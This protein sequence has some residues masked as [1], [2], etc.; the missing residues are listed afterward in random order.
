MTNRTEEFGATYNPVSKNGLPVLGSWVNAFPESSFNGTGLRLDNE[1]QFIPSE[2]AAIINCVFAEPTGEVAFDAKMSGYF[3][4]FIFTEDLFCANITMLLNDKP[5]WPSFK[6][7]QPFEEDL[8]LE[9]V[10]YPEWFAYT[11]M[12]RTLY[13]CYQFIEA[14]V[15]EPDAFEFA[16]EE[17][18]IYSEL[19]SESLEFWNTLKRLKHDCKLDRNKHDISINMLGMDIEAQKKTFKDQENPLLEVYINNIDLGFEVK[20][21]QEGQSSLV[22]QINAHLHNK[23]RLLPL[24][25][26]IL[27]RLS[28]INALLYGVF[29]LREMGYVMPDDMKET[30]KNI[31]Y[32][33]QQRLEENGDTQYCTPLPYKK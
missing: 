11:E 33:F 10:W 15:F 3:P 29:Q 22:Q 8:H 21:K 30:H 23:R 14:L 32:N 27:E 16:A 2:G 7:F 5:Q 24:L 19:Y 17:D 18:F 26:P 25:L 9:K 6:M 4:A 12:G 13:T 1:P 20:P 31:L 28:Q